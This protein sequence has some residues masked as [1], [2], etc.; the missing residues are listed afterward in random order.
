MHNAISDVTRGKEAGK[1]ATRTAC[2]HEYK[3]QAN[4]EGEVNTMPWQPTRRKAKK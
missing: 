3:V 4:M 1:E 2:E